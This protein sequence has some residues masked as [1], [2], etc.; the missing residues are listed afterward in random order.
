MLETDK[1]KRIMQVLA[2]FGVMVLVVVAIAASVISYSVGYRTAEAECE[3]KLEAGNSGA[4]IEI[5]GDDAEFQS[6]DKLDEGQIPDHYIGSDNPQIT[7][8]EYADYPCPHCAEL[9]TNL[10][11]VYPNYSDSVRFIFRHFNV[12]FIHS[13][14]TAKIAEAAYVV[15]GEDAYWMM[16]DKLFEHSAD[17]GDE[18][19]LADSDIENRIIAYGNEIGIDGNAVLD[20]YNN[21][22]NNGIDEKLSRDNMSGA[23][24]GITSTPTVFIDGVSINT[25]AQAISNKLDALLQ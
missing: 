12:G 3:T 9:A 21:S 14:T 11:S 22:A 4:V 2:V 18:S 6:S 1:N 19:S 10:E 8:I 13:S 17:W 16:H 20:A 23:N 15:G 5:T 25:N 24:A 7:V